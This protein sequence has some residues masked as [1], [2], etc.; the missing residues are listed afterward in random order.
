MTKTGRILITLILTVAIPIA[1]IFLW[2]NQ[3][4]IGDAF[5]GS[6]TGESQLFFTILIAIFSYSVATSTIETAYVPIIALAAAGFFGGLSAGSSKN[7]FVGGFLGVILLFVIM[8]V[9]MY[10]F[11]L[12]TLG[13]FFKNLTEG[14]KFY[15]N[16][17]VL[18]GLLVIFPTII[19][20]IFGTATESE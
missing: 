1:G 19:G 10:P 4:G 3:Y 20:A 13:S 11:S 5:F 16:I 14:P 6:L 12:D 2:L 17:G 9:L 7:G 15:R 8:V 18:F